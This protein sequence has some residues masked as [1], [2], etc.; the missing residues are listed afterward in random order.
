MMQ[1]KK[2]MQIRQIYI[3][4]HTHTLA[5]TQGESKEE[6]EWERAKK[7][8]PEQHLNKRFFHYDST[9]IFVHIFVCGSRSNAFGEEN[10][11]VALKCW[12]KWSEEEKSGQKGVIARLDTQKL[13][14]VCVCVVAIWIERCSVFALLCTH[15]H[16]IDWFAVKEYYLK[17]K[18]QATACTK[19][20]KK[21]QCKHCTKANLIESGR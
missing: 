11:A 5:D 15:F 17:I 9:Q 6:K 8:I 10:L 13:S 1:G 16:S 20:K 3:N 18:Q 14:Q 21:V 12:W 7:N 2:L 19:I 4:T